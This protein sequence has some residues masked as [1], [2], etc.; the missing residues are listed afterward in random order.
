[1]ILDE[2]EIP[3]KRYPSLDLRYHRYFWIALILAGTYLTHVDYLGLLR[4]FG[5]GGM[6][7]FMLFN[8]VYAPHGWITRLFRTALLVAMI[9]FINIYLLDYFIIRFRS[10]LYFGTFLLSYLFYLQRFGKKFKEVHEV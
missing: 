10:Y 7:G 8:L 3:I 6:S 4:W 2:D 5:F 9:V 1:V